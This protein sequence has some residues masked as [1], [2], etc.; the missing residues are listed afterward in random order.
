[1]EYKPSYLKKIYV[2]PDGRGGS[3]TLYEVRIKRVRIGAIA[4]ERRGRKKIGDKVEI[5]AIVPRYMIDDGE[6]SSYRS[7][8]RCHDR[9]SAFDCIIR[10]LEQSTYGEEL[11]ATIEEGATK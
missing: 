8:P 2:N 9:K 3:V 10:K 7:A 6:L 5:T 11:L 1:M 4:I